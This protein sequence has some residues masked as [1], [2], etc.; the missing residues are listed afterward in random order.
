[1]SLEEILKDSG[2]SQP[3][4]TIGDDL[5]RWIQEAQT[6]LDFALIDEARLPVEDLEQLRE[7]AGSLHPELAWFYQHATPWIRMGNG[8]QIWREHMEIACRRL[9][10][11][12]QRRGPVDKAKFQQNIA[13]QPAVLPV[14]L[15]RKATALAFTDVRGRLAVIGGNIGPYFG[16]PMAIGMRNYLVQQVLVEIVW[17]DERY[18]T[19]AESMEDPHVRE[20][21]GWPPTDPPRHLFIELY[22]A[23]RTNP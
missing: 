14:N 5:L 1:M 10:E 16:R 6:V 19:Y 4:L 13:A 22:Q 18:A 17:C 12:A 11:A 8:L 9:H 21:G 3:P 2:L 23:S 7:Q 15:S 20:A